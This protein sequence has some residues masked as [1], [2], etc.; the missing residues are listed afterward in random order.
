MT[1]KY[2]NPMWHA[3]NEG[4]TK[5]TDSG[6]GVGPLIAKG[7][8]HFIQKDN[9]D[10]VVSLLADLLDSTIQVSTVRELSYLRQPLCLLKT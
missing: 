7:C 5:I 8:G 1:T 10:L 2:L 3:Y 9:P 4:L 6:R